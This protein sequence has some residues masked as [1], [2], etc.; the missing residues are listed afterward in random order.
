M[1]NKIIPVSL[2]VVGLAAL[3]LGLP[4]LAWGLP[5]YG[6]D[7]GT[8]NMPGRVPSHEV[9]VLSWQNLPMTF[10]GIIGILSGIGFW[11]IQTERDAA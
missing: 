5:D 6:R 10:I 3:A 2:I 7:V 11:R 4:D 8:I 1:N 9:V